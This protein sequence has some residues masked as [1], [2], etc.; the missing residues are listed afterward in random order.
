MWYCLY[1]APST[2]RYPPPM[3]D[4]GLESL[5]GKG[6]KH[7]IAQVSGVTRLE[8]CPLGQRL[9]GWSDHRKRKPIV[10]LRRSTLILWPQ[11][12]DQIIEHLNLTVVCPSAGCIRLSIKWSYNSVQLIERWQS[13]YL[14]SNVRLVLFPFPT[15]H[16]SIFDI[17]IVNIDFVMI[18]ST[19]IFQVYQGKMHIQKFTCGH[20]LHSLLSVK[21]SVLNLDIRQSLKFWKKAMDYPLLSCFRFIKNDAKWLKLIQNRFQDLRFAFAFRIMTLQKFMSLK[22]DGSLE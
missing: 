13:S 7:P 3:R 10:R 4:L 17:D 15:F 9:L 11:S 19:K 16:R 21:C 1:V 20:L 18:S 2:P 6:I 12:Y 8:P 5:A 22:H 14:I